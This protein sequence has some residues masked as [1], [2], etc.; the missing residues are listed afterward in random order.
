C[1]SYWSAYLLP[2]AASLLP[3]NPLHRPLCPRPARK[4]NPA[5]HV[6]CA[7]QP[8]APSQSRNY[9]LQ[10][11]NVWPGRTFLT[12]PTTI[13]HRLGQHYDHPVGSLPSS[14]V[15]VPLARQWRLWVSDP[16]RN[17]YVSSCKHG[18]NPGR[19]PTLMVVPKEWSPD[20]TSP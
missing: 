18:W 8:P 17:R 14:H 13:W 3:R 6:Q 9:K 12:G 19:L 7:R 1:R 20:T 2:A 11:Y 15:G 10:H 5:R 4:L 16:Q